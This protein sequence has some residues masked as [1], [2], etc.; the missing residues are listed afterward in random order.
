MPSW[1]EILNDIRATGSSFDVV[2]RRFL[3]SLHDNTGRNVI[4]YYS[5]WLQKVD[6]QG[7][8]ERLMGVDD[9]DKNGFMAV[10]HGLDRKLG[11]DLILHTPGGSVAATES[12]VDYLLN[13]FD[14]NI[15]VI[16]PQLAMS[17]GTM[18]ACAAHT[19]VMGKQSSLGPIDPQVGGVAA[20]GILEEI[21]DILEQINSNPQTVPIWQIIVAKYPPTLIG[22]CTKSIQWANEVVRE[23]LTAGMLKNDS[24]SGAKADS[25]IQ[26][27]GDHALTKSH[28]RHLSAK[29]CMEM[30]LTIKMME[31]DNVFQD[32]ILSVHHSNIHTLTS[33]AAY[34]II[35][36]HKGVA[37]IQ[38]VPS[39]RI[40]QS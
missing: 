33:T 40:I 24:N 21:D 19:I 27:L 20:H 8:L 18:I 34:K 29:R 4:T 10:V 38:A 23:W 35:E 22:E 1:H 7:V 37:F 2:R 12:I 28:S 3:A 39:A 16:V 14:G 17:A 9:S 15:R 30:G 25:I 6:P 5:G 36:N 32:L 13:M 26:E 11:L 31:D